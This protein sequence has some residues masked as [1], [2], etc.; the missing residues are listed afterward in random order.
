MTKNKVFDT[1]RKLGAANAKV[2]FSGGGDEGGVDQITLHNENGE[3]IKSLLENH[4]YHEKNGKY[5][6]Y[7][8]KTNKQ[9]VVNIT[10]EEKLVMNLVKPVYE[11]Y[12]TFAGEFYV[13][14]CVTWDAINRKV[15]MN[16]SE[17]VRHGE[18]FEEE[19]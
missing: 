13:N 6:K 14:G 3:E 16:G 12:H 7:D 11:K 19:F 8:Y 1:I 9:E 2:Y 17:E 5:Y 18:D 10:D 15:L 4:N